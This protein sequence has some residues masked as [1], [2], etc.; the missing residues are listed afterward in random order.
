M[1]AKRIISSIVI[2]CGL[3][4]LLASATTEARAEK[5]IDQPAA[6]QKE[7]TGA[8][9]YIGLIKDLNLNKELVLQND[10]Y[11]EDPGYYLEVSFYQGGM[12]KLSTGNIPPGKEAVFLPELYL[13]EGEATVLEQA[14]IQNNKQCVPVGAPVQQTVYFFKEETQ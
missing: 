2:T 9:S 11:N 1:T 14:Y 5:R 10:I 13:A 4:F 3:A 7:V 6:E 12:R 8:C